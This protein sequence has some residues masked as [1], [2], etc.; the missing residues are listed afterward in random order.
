MRS[1]RAGVESN[2]ECPVIPL[3]VVSLVRTGN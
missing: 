2:T 1:A 3:D